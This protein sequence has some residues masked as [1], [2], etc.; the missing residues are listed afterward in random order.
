MESGRFVFSCGLLYKTQLIAPPRAVQEVSRPRP[1]Y[2]M[3]IED[4]L[5]I[6]GGIPLKGSV[7]VS[8]GK[9]AAVAI[10]PAALLAD[11]VSYIENLPE[12]D[13]VYVL[14]EMLIELGAQVEFKNGVMRIDARTLSSYRP[15][16]ELACR[17]RA[18]YYLLGVLLGRFGKAEVPLPGGCDIGARPI[19]QTVKGLTMLGVNYESRAGVMY[20]SGQ[21][22]HGAD[23]YLDMPSVGATMNTILTAVLAQ[24]VTQ[25]HNAAREPHVVDLANFL[26]SMGAS[27]KG[28]GTDTIRIRGVRS[29][30]GTH[31]TIIPDQIETGTL[32]LAAAVTHG[33]VESH[34]V[35]PTHMEA[36]TAKMLEMGI[37]VHSQE[38]VI[39]VRATAGR[40]RGLTIKTQYYPGF[41]TDLQQPMT[42]LLC[43]SG[44]SSV[45]SETIYESRFK[46][47]EE[48]L[49][50][51]ANIRVMDRIAIIEGVDRLTGCRVHAPDLRA[52]AALV[53]AALGCEGVAEISGVRFIDRGYDR[54]EEKLR[55]LGAHIERVRMDVG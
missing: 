37:Y 55:S 34:G 2:D 25:I 36:L 50:M 47:A 29:L 21:E 1:D 54:M 6:W 20:V 4:V 28:A 53:V 46:Y 41:P 27:I 49:R 23:V 17:M 39:H 43:T 12:I 44:G 22:L 51:G 16:L 33:D 18:S 35:I 42:A 14:E 11:D 45:V 15:P 13:D 26:N 5:R 24:G 19:D 8:G 30:H 48:L 10:I 3:A 40:P 52:G 31:Y 32:M 9:N 38:D 7:T